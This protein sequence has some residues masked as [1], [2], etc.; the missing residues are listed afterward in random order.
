MFATSTYPSFPKMN[1]VRPFQRRIQLSVLPAKW[2]PE[3]KKTAFLR[4]AC[5]GTNQRIVSAE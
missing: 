2:L 5:L 1:W 3:A 4:K